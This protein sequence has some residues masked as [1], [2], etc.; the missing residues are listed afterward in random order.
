M[1]YEEM[2]KFIAENLRLEAE[3]KSNYTGS[4]DGPMYT[5]STTIKL[6]FCGNV[7]S[8]VGI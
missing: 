1:T 7:I 2:I 8:E 3:T 6:V 5:D 4:S